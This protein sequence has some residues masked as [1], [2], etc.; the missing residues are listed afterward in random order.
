MDRSNTCPPLQY[1]S[2][3]S[4]NK[5]AWT[6][7]AAGLEKDL[8]SGVDA[9]PVPQEPMVRVSPTAHCLLNRI[10]YI[11]ANLGMSTNFGAVD[12]THI[13]FPTVLSLD[14]VRVYQ[15]E[16]AI[17]IGCDPPDFP[18][19]EYINTYVWFLYTRD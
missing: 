17:N 5:V 14:Y 3:I 8:Q 2:W 11:L 19:S 7:Q 10:K 4:D 16:D 6:V 13:T 18:T 9:R 12:T 15:Y 1:I